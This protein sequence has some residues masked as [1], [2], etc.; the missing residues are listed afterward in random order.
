MKIEADSVWAETV[1]ATRVPAW[2]R[3]TGPSQSDVDAAYIAGAAL[4]SLD[5][6]VRGEP[7]YGGVLRQRLALKA[8]VAA[9]RLI[10]RKEDESQLRDADLLRFP[11]DTSGPGGDLLVAW[12]RMAHRSATLDVDAI[13]AISALLEIAWDDALAEIVENANV[14]LSSHR[15]APVIA[16]ELMAEIYRARPKAELL[17]YWL[18]D[19]LI[20]ARFRWAQPVPLL[21]GQIH[22]AAFKGDTG[23]RL[24]PGES[25]WG[26]V[27]LLACAKGAVDA[28]D[29]AVE[30]A[31]KAERLMAVAPKLRAKGA[32][33]VLKMLLNED[34]I[35]SSRSRKN[36]SD[37]GARRLFERLHDLGVVRELSG[38]SSFRLYGL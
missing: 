36:L 26:R 33:E 2:A 29:L 38:R 10:G 21:M 8:A 17:A 15:P 6:L 12:R 28:C 1:Q 35:S 24:R 25:G 18:G 22:T 34:A 19:V 31:D 27:V 30:L 9:A 3:P 23:R 7:T 4:H 5:F 32:G 20:A 14:L 37:R 13:I 16:A 11:G